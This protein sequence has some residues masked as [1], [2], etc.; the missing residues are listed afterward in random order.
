MAF[1]MVDSDNRII[2]WSEEHLDGMD[3]YFKN[4]H[5]IDEKCVNGLNDFLIVD[6]EAVF[7]PT[8]ESIYLAK[9]RSFDS[10]EASIDLMD[11]VFELGEITSK[12]QATNE[13][14]MDALIELAGMIASM[15]E[16][17]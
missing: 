2:S 13:E 17:A 3:V 5:Y 7:Q 6:D 15:Q 16:G 14:I 1:A 11:A 10:Y 9:K 4:G 8:E 12:Q